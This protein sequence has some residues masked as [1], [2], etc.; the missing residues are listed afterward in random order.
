MNDKQNQ[1]N[2]DSVPSQKSIISFSAVG[3]I[4]LGSN[5]PSPSYLPPA[6]QPEL[7][8][9]ADSLLQQ[10]D[11]SFGNCEGTF[12]NAG[13][14][15]K[16]TGRNIYCFRQPESFAEKLVASGFDLISIANNHIN[17]FGPAGILSTARALEKQQLHY[18]GI[19]AHPYDIVEKGKIK[20]G[21]IAFAPHAGCLD[22]NDIPRAK[23]LVAELKS[24]TDIVMVSFHGGAEGS[25]AQHVTRKT[26]MFYNQNRGNVYLFAHNMIDAGAD[27]VIGHGP[28]VVRAMELYK[29]RIISY[30]LGNFCTYG[31][32]NLK[33]VNSVAPLLQFRVNGRGEFVDGKIHSFKQI[34]EGGPILDDQ[35][36]AVRLIRQLTKSDIPETGLQ[37]SEEGVLSVSN[38]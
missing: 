6:N 16:D 4:M 31:Q 3:D 18:A 20:I 22:M 14:I 37:I 8:H 21:L 15:P 25:S 35:K 1:Q 19:P 29:S 32:F 36:Q 17:D 24:K 5:F 38:N 30:S 23:L 26:E 9:E 11:F 7:L 2:S 27:I 34:N 12:L 10:T 28:H 13:G 33:G